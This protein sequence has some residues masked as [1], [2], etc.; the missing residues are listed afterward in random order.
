MPIIPSFNKETPRPSG[1]I[2]WFAVLAGALAIAYAARYFI[3]GGLN[4]G[5]FL[6][7]AGHAAMA[8]FGL[9]KAFRSNLNKSTKPVDVL[10]INDD[11]E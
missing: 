4:S 10:K 8:I 2:W 9:L 5:S 11:E 6:T 7:S 1:G 3:N